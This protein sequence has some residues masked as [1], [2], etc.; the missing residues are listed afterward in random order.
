MRPARARPACSVNPRCEIPAQDIMEFLVE[1]EDIP[2][3]VEAAPP[4]RWG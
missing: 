1:D 4:S 2:W 3:P